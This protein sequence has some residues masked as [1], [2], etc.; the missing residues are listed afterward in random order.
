VIGVGWRTRSL[1]SAG[2]S[3]KESSPIWVMTVQDHKEPDK[4]KICFYFPV[5]GHVSNRDLRKMKIEP[6]KEG[7]VF[8]KVVGVKFDL[9]CVGKQNMEK[10]E[11]LRSN[12]LRFF[13]TQTVCDISDSTKTPMTAEIIRRDDYFAGKIEVGI[14]TLNEEGLKI[15]FDSACRI[16][17]D[18]ALDLKSRTLETNPE[19]YGALHNK[20]VV[21]KGLGRF[22]EALQFFNKAAQISPSETNVWY[23]MANCYESLSRSSDAVKCYDKAIEINPQDPESYLKK[24]VFFVNTGCFDEAI[25]LF[26]KAIAVNPRPPEPWY[27]KAFCLGKLNRYGEAIQCYTEALKLNPEFAAALFNKG[28]AEDKLG[29]RSDATESFRKL[30]ELGTRV[31]PKYV[32]Y[33]RK[34]LRELER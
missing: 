30:V 11:E 6:Q 26:D 24:G 23:D 9:E 18:I 14:Q 25:Q 20:G 12:L 8:R 3:F 33:A 19:D 1:T 7:A 5:D 13:T 32:E 4:T 27:N 21:L 15:L 28:L 17:G 16:A 22:T 34:R 2:I 31:G 10:D 29:R